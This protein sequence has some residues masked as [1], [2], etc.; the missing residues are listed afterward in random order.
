MRCPTY[1]SEYMNRLMYFFLFCWISNGTLAQSYQ[2]RR[3]AG[4]EFFSSSHLL[5][6]EGYIYHAFNI[7]NGG[8]E[9][10][11][12]Y[13]IKADENLNVIDSSRVP[14]D[15]TIYH[16][17]PYLV[18]LNDQI[19]GLTYATDYP[20]VPF[21]TNY[22][23]FKPEILVFDTT[24]VLQKRINLQRHLGRF[25]FNVRIFKVEDS[26]LLITSTGRT[27]VP[28]TFFCILN[29][30]G[31]LIDTH[32]QHN[33]Y[34]YGNP[35]GRLSGVNK[36]FISFG[37][38]NY[39]FTLRPF[40]LSSIDTILNAIQYIQYNIGQVN[41]IVFN[42]NGDVYYADDDHIS[43]G[44]G[45]EITILK[46]NNIGELK[47]QVKYG[48]RLNDGMGL[49]AVDV[50]NNEDLI[51]ASYHERQIPTS[52]GKTHDLVVSRFDKDLRL[53]WRKK[54]MLEGSAFITVSVV[55]TPDNGATI[56]SVTLDTNQVNTF[57][58]YNDLHIL[59]IDSTGYYSPLSTDDFEDMWSSSI[60]VFPNPVSIDFSISGLEENE[61]YQAGVYDVEGN[62][63]KRLSVS[64]PFEVELSGIKAGSYLLILQDNEGKRVTRRFVKQ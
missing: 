12:T 64:Y 5:F 32:I 54:L 29:S 31:D 56:L 28:S 40:Q 38:Y 10:P 52:G 26:L 58:G 49:E 46:F 63:V 4:P 13:L 59:H 6:K 35:I 11:K 15:S 44:L 47:A 19:F 24:L 53:K 7:S 55:G 3:I 2:E 62:L 27:G 17:M 18:S 33:S 43:P 39:N 36:Y 1:Y 61:E 20:A 45:N 9:N 42:S 23:H 57:I 51:L 50:T 37:R 21:D 34:L 22:K 41:K 30:K 48:D 25:N 8:L 14:I 16:T 60:S